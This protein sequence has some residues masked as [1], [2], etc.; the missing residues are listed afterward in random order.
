MNT[1]LDI[2]LETDLIIVADY[3]FIEFDYNSIHSNLFLKNGYCVTGGKNKKSIRFDKKSLDEAQISGNLV[4]IF[5]T[6]GK[7]HK[8]ELMDLIEKNC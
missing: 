6:K 7:L 2:I 8:L 4:S 5:D 3:Y 1:I